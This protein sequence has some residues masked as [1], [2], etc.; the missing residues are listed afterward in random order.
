VPLSKHY[1]LT[2]IMKRRKKDLQ[3]IENKLKAKQAMKSSR[4]KKETVKLPDKF[5]KRYRTA[6]RSFT[7]V[8]RRV[9]LFMEF[10]LLR[11]YST[12]L[13]ALKRSAYCWW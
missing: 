11:P 4:P 10:R 2:D 7:D 8:K 3:A 5:V 1:V 12:T 9:M 13:L 6:Q